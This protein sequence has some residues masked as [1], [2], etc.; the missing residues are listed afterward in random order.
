MAQRAT[1]LDHGVNIMGDVY[2]V[3]ENYGF[4]TSVDQSEDNPFWQ[5]NCSR[6]RMW[7]IAQ[8]KRIGENY[9]FKTI[10]GKGHLAT[11][12][13]T[14]IDAVLL[15]LYQANGLFGESAAEAFAVTVGASVNTT[16]TVAQ[17]E[18]NAVA[19]VIFS[20]HAKVVNISLVTIPVTGKVSQG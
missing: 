14:D 11:S 17:G 13:K 18:L 10:D 9:M 8:C 4:Q 1:L 12:L 2:G 3:L 16:G 6:G 15:Q 7:I 20:E 5:A 19:E